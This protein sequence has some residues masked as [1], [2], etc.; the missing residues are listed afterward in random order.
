M[1][2]SSNPSRASLLHS[3]GMTDSKP[4]IFTNVHRGIRNASFEA[5][6]ALGRAGSDP[7]RIDAART[8]LLDVL[9]F[10][11]HHG[12]IE[13]RFLLPLLEHRAPHLAAR[14][15]VAHEALDRPL[16][17]LRD[18]AGSQEAAQLQHRF[19]AFLAAY[20]EHMR[21]EEEELDPAIREAVPA[22]ELLTFG[23]NAVEHT[24]P[25]DR[26]RMLRWMLG[27]MPPDEAS[28]LLSRLPGALAAELRR[29][30]A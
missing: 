10:I 15:R 25:A 5:C 24:E 11:S 17:A 13:D 19:G 23:R 9:H 2:V 1:S 29:V 4:D 21:E 28:T 12:T 20:L 8:L 7:S 30:L 27:A 3:G 18:A 26:P 14:M 16:T 6:L 22:E